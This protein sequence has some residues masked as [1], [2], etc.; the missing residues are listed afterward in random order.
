VFASTLLAQPADAHAPDRMTEAKLARAFATAVAALAGS[1][2]LVCAAV[3][4]LR[5]LAGAFE[6]APTPLVVLAVTAAGVGLVVLCDA[7]ARRAHASTRGGIVAWGVVARAGLAVALAAVSLP[8]ALATPLDAIALAASLLFAGVTIAAPVATAAGVR[9]PGRERALPQ[10]PPATVPRP[11][12]QATD[13]PRAPACPGHLVQR[14][15]RYELDGTDCLRGMLTIAVPQGARS[16]HAHIGFCPSFKQLPHVDV[17]TEYDG[18]EAVVSAAE[19]VPW[20]ARVECR[21]DEPAEEA[22]EISVD[23]FAQSPS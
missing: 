8:A 22:I 9:R 20:G 16:A 21:L 5:R 4:G 15:E 1:L 12:A 13:V 19:V 18:V 6:T 2:A 11:T 7:L 23:L 17:T 14:L 3:L 10:Q